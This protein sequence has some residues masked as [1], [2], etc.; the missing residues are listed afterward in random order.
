[1]IPNRGLLSS[2]C[3]G[4]LLLVA[5]LAAGGCAGRTPGAAVESR[6]TAGN[7]AYEKGDFERAAEIYREIASTGVRSAALHY[8]LGN[9][10][11]KAGRLG[12]A[13][14]EYE[15]AHLLDPGDPDVRDNLEYLRSLTV[16]EITPAP[17]P[18]SAL[19][20]GDLLDLTTPAQDAAVL[21]LGWLLAGLAFGIGVA[22]HAEGV[23]R[24]A[25]YA[26]GA[27]MLP[28]LLGGGLLGAK[29]WEDSSMEFGVVIAPEAEVLSGAGQEN[30]ALFTVHEGLRVRIHARSEGWTQVSLE[31]GLTGW[32]PDESVEEI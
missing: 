32:L 20:I 3:A 25:F 19:G 12:E 23:K 29:S 27:L 14:L 24:S 7:D 17:S 13:L 2:R 26:A 1:M 8:N 10:L 28:A 5:L 18:L 9:A 22:A 6:F 11:F 16:D 4:A 15:R 21:L 31:N 30:P